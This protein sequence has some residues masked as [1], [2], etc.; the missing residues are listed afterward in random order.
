MECQKNDIRAKIRAI[1]SVFH[2]ALLILIV[3]SVVL[4]GM[5]LFAHFWSFM[6]WSGEVVEIIERRPHERPPIIHNLTIPDFFHIGETNVFLYAIHDMGGAGFR[7]S[8]RTVF[9]IITIFTAERMFNLLKRG[10]VPF[11]EGVTSWFKL[12]TISFF[13][14]NLGTNLSMAITSIVILAISF[15]FDYGRLLQEESDTTL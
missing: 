5:Q 3:L 4:G 7:A 11:S 6:G 12:F 1:S 13:I 8:F 10:E 14:W 15:I 9:L 2:I